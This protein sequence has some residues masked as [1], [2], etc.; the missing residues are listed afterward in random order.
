[1][2]TTTIATVVLAVAALGSFVVTARSLR[3]TRTD[4]QQSRFS[5][6]D[7]RSPRVIARNSSE[8]ILPASTPADVVTNID[9]RLPVDR[10]FDLPGAADQR[11][12]LVC[13]AEL[14]N[15]G[16]ATAFLHLPAGAIPV[17]GAQQRPKE[18]EPKL[19]TWRAGRSLQDRLAPGESRWYLLEGTRTVAEWSRLYAL[20]GGD[21]WARPPGTPA[22]GT[23]APGDVPGWRFTFR[24][25]DQFAEGVED[26]LVIDALCLPLKPVEGSGSSWQPRGPVLTPYTPPISAIEVRPT[27]RHYKPQDQPRGFR[28]LFAGL[29]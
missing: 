2:D 25:S 8:P 26:L 21:M 27:V 6:I 9:V 5:R 13:Y 1:V 24:M 22:A 11:V 28:R 14:F 3:L 15:E 23:I 12:T 29:M 19:L 16:T 4:V 7:A 18:S 20:Y 17:E 10:R